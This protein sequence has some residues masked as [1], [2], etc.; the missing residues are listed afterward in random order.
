MATASEVVL[1]EAIRSRRAQAQEL[2]AQIQDLQG[3]KDVLQ[4]EIQNIKASLD[5]LGISE[6]PPQEVPT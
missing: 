1:R 5:A 2:T 3:R 4:S 6:A